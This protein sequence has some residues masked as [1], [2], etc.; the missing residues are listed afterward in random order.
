M[1]VKTKTHQNNWITFYT[2]CN[3]RTLNPEVL[4]T[5]NIGL[6]VIIS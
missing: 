3:R 4:A 2:R 1:W 5:V 6:L